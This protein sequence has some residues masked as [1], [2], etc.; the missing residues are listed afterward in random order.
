MFS[1]NRRK[2]SRYLKFKIKKLV[3]ILTKRYYI[4]EKEDNHMNI[5]KINIKNHNISIYLQMLKNYKN[6]IF[7]YNYR[8]WINKKSYIDLFLNQCLYID[9]YYLRFDSNNLCQ[10]TSLR[11]FLFNIIKDKDDLINLEKAILKII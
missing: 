8:V 4:T 1:I 11:N 9:I 5:F 10:R 6:H 2:R 3:K 7:I